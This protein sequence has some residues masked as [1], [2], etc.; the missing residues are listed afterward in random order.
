MKTKNM[1]VLFVLTSLTLQ[2]STFS[3]AVEAKAKGGADGGGGHS[4]TCKNKKSVTL[5]F[6]NAA[7]KAEGAAHLLDP[8]KDDLEMIIEQRLNNS[9]FDESF[10]D[11][12]KFGSWLEKKITAL[13]PI[14]GWAD[15]DLKIIQDHNLI[16]MLPSGCVLEQAAAQE[17]N[18]DELEMYQNS[19]VTNKLSLGQKKI[20]QIHEALYS[21]IRSNLGTDSRAVRALLEKILLK[22]LP[23]DV[24]DV[25]IKNFIASIN[26]NANRFVC[27]ARG[28]TALGVN[29]FL[30]RS[31]QDLSF[32]G[33]T[34]Q[35]AFSKLN[36]M[37]K[38]GIIPC[39]GFA[40]VW[41]SSTATC[42]QVPTIGSNCQS[43]N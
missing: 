5:D 2:L 9:S 8:D 43:V 35:E 13:G 27:Q 4:V 33:K 12:I 20:L 37:R 14:E 24:R 11:N 39:N 10:T 22:D 42:E 15:G 18:G 28:Y 23:D 30:K 36:D 16:Y 32:Y 19:R 38:D 3:T 34:M 6:Y 40:D 1:K 21:L 41:S 25:A 29:T 7:I 31:V 17:D 26:K